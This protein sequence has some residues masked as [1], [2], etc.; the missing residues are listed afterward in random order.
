MAGKPK[1]APAKKKQPPAE[2]SSETIAAQTEAFLKAGGK[3]D[4]VARGVTGYQGST[5]S[6]QISLGNKP[7]S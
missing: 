2:I 5:G 4:Q 6:R 1:T 7:R 3:I